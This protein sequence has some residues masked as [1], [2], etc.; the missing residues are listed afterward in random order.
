MELYFGLLVWHSR[1]TIFLAAERGSP[2]T[3]DSRDQPLIVTMSYMLPLVTHVTLAG[4]ITNS[5][6][7]NNANTI[8]NK[9]IEGN[10]A[11]Q[12][13]QFVLYRIL[14]KMSFVLDLYSYR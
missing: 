2:D 14:S 8:G 6:L 3:D 12:V 9:A 4:E 7:T 10:V 1:H 13:S 5:I 11:R